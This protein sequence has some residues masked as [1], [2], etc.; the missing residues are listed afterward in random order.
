MTS[1]PK[2]SLHHVALTVSDVDASVSWYET[3]F[4]MH[5]RVDVPHG[6]VRAD[7]ADK[8]LTRSA[9]LDEEAFNAA[10]G[11]DVITTT[12]GVPGFGLI[13]VNAFVLHGTE[14]VLVDTGPIVERD[15]FLEALATVIDPTELRWIWL[16]HP[17]FDH[18]GSL[19]ALL[20]ANAQLRVITTFLGMGIMGLFAPPPVDR[21]YLVNPG[22]DVTLGDRCLRAFRPPTF[23]N[24]STTGF[25][26]EGSGVVFSSDCFGAL[27]QEVPRRA[28]DLS[29]DDLRAGQQ[30]WATVDAPWLHAV[31]ASLL[32]K[33][34]ETVRAME[35][36]MVLSSHLPPAPGGLVDRMVSNLAGVPQIEPFV[37]PDQAAMEQM[38]AAM[39]GAPP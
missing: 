14:P 35:P 2:L 32:A 11:I 8:P 18:I 22:Q 5:H 39:I 25:R 15:Q 13:P 19:H 21:A 28:D 10:P 20:E 3:L 23:D 31:D 24:P 34:L 36:S 30:F 4:G 27:L 9:I 6:V 33:H 16:S 17:D 7:P 37:G 12:L 29:E 1:T 38:M 26:D